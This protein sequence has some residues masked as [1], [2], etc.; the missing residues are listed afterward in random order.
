LHC[1]TNALIAATIETRSRSGRTEAAPVNLPL[2][3]SMLESIATRIAPPAFAIVAFSLASGCS[4]PDKANI[5]IRKQKQ[6]LESKIES[7]ERQHAAD[8]A[9]IR[10]LESRATTVPTLPNDR[11]DKLFTV[12]GITLGRLTGGA[13]LDPEKPGDDGLKVYVVPTDNDG[14][15]LKAAGSFVVEAFDLA[16][17]ENNRIGRWEFNVNE[18]RKHWFGQA[19]LYTYVLPAPWQTPPEHPDIT[20]RVGFTDELTGRTF[21]TQKVIRVTPPKVR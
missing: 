3:L 11:L 2:Y 15:P 8:V 5:E 7:L 13:D 12:H 16:K 10:S 14:Q 18:A 6:Q 9:S 17:G 1:A 20:L 21:N 4:S 19:M